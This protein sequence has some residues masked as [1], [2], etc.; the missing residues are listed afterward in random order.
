MHTSVN[1][2]NRIL[3]S[4]CNTGTYG[5][6]CESRCDTCVSRI[7]DRFYGKCAYGC[8]GGFNGDRC[9]ITGITILV[10]GVDL[11]YFNAHLDSPS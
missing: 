4:D 6:N 7:C 5:L 3:F 1:F 9:N 10:E 8:I 2:H 11:S